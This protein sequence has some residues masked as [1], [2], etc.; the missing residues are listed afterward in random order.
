[1]E[2][3]WEKLKDRKEKHKNIK[4]YKM[5]KQLT[6]HYISCLVPQS[7]A[8]I[9]DYNT[10]T[11]SALPVVRTRTSLYY[12]SFI[13]SS[14]RLWSLQPDTIRLSPFIQ[15]LK[16]S[17]KSNTSSEPLYY[18]ADSRLVQILHSRLRMQCSSLNQHLYRKNVVGSP[19]CI[20]GLAEST[21]HYLFPCPRYTVQR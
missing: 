6:P 13:P 16:Y 10:R 18:Y 3:G 17:L 7:F 5:T 20:C 9:H 12:N 15:A 21:T 4:F 11:A 19:N 1:M 2:T 8:N 14:V